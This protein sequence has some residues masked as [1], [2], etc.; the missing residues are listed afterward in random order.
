MN[1]FDQKIIRAKKNL[2]LIFEHF[3]LKT[4]HHLFMRQ[5]NPVRGLFVSISSPSRSAIHHDRFYKNLWL[6]DNHFWLKNRLYYDIQQ[7]VILN[8]YYLI[9]KFLWLIDDHLWLKNRLYY[10][11]Q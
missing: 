2:W 10:D 3:W 7:L 8:T 4:I 5:P 6:I 1:I 11:I 9:L